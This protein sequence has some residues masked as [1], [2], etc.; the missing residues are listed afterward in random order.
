MSVAGG[1]V[2]FEI[3]Q[4][5]GLAHPGHRRGADD[6][7]DRFGARGGITRRLAR[8]ENPNIYTHPERIGGV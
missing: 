1:R 4:K 8:G 5:A 6:T 3:V 7:G 2:A